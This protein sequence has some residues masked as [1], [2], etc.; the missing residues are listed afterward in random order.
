MANDTTLPAARVPKALK[1]RLVKHAESE[2][3][4]VS[5]IIKKAVEEYLDR[6]QEGSV[7]KD[8]DR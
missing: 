1:E 2:E 4:T 5:W 8:S 6:H 7:G 3:R